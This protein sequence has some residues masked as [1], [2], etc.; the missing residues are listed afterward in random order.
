MADGWKV[1]VAR[2]LVVTA[3]V[4]WVWWVDDSDLAVGVLACVAAAGVG[5]ALLGRLAARARA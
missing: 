3:L 5:L 2:A 1:T 4:T